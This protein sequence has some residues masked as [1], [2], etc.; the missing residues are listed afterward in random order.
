[1]TDPTSAAIATAIV[2]KTVEIAGGQAM[3]AVAAVVRKVRD[4]FRG[5]AADEAALTAAE[6]NPESADRIAELA[7]A[8]R[9][10]ALEDPVFDAELRG[11]W[12][13]VRMDMTAE[14]DGV[15]NS[16]RG[17]ANK[18]VQVHDVHGDLNIN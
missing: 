1:M 10:A 8:L 9:R 11:L 15:V 16:F 13:Q 7:D 12:N 14:H 4:K 18:V 5:R 3:E 17:Q 6:E 2:G